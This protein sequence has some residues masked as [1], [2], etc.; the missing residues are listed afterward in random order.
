MAGF[1]LKDIAQRYGD[2]AHFVFK[3]YPIDRACNTRLTRDAHTVA[4]ESAQ[5]VIC[6]GQQGKFWE[7]HD[8]TFDAQDDLSTSKLQRIAK[9]VGLD[10]DKWQ[11]CKESDASVDLVKE[12]I[13]QAWEIG[14]NGTPSFLVNGKL[15][16]M[17]HPLFVEAAIRQ[18][19]IARG[20]MSLPEDEEQIFG[21]I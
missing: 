19:L 16:P 21:D 9:E 13:S 20:E 1:F 8:L 10:Y 17:A 4:C 3:N 5:S 6:A 11:D 2:R 7:M 15:L 14:L 12:Q 18:E